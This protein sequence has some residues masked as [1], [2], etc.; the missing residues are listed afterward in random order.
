MTLS[1]WL[2]TIALVAAC[3]VP[4][5]AQTDQGKLTGSVRDSSGAF[6]AGAKVT[7]KNERTGEERST[8]SND[9]GFFLIPSL[10]PSAYTIRSEKSGFGAIEYTGMTLAV[11]QELALDFELKPA[12][13][14]EAVTVTASAPVLDLSSA[15]VGVNVST[16]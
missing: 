15:R 3:A 12:G 7:A 5:L 9:Q 2:A 1:K 10:K 16:R 14:Q 6:V 8:V 13:V 11:G 4:G